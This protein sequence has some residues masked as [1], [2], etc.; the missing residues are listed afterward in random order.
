[1]KISL[2][3]F[4]G[5]ALSACLAA[6]C[7]GAGSDSWT[8]MVYMNSGQ[9]MD[10]FALRDFEQI[11]TVRSLPNAPA[12]FVELGRPF[13]TCGEKW[14]GVR[15]YRVDP[16]SR[17]SVTGG[18]PVHAPRRA[19][20]NSA[21]GEDPVD[22]GSGQTV[23]DFVKWAMSR[24]PPTQHYALIIW[25]HGHGLTLQYS[26]DLFKS[27]GLS[28]P[29]HLHELLEQV[30]SASTGPLGTDLNAGVGAFG[31][32]AANKPGADTV[33]D[34]P[35]YLRDLAD[36]LS[37]VLGPRHLDILAMDSCLMGA[38]ENAWELRNVADYSLAS[39]TNIMRG[40]WNYANLLNALTTPQAPKAAVS[41]I[42]RKALYYG[43]GFDL[44]S[45]ISGVD[46]SQADRMAGLI[47]NLAG[48][49]EKVLGNSGVAAGLYQLRKKSIPSYSTLST[50]AS[51]VDLKLLTQKL[52]DMN[53]SF[54]VNA[55]A[56]ALNRGL[57]FDPNLPQRHDFIV[58]NSSPT[59]DNNGVSIFFPRS[60][61]EWTNFNMSHPGAQSYDPDTCTDS[62]LS[63]KISF[64]CDSKQ[65]W[66]RFIKQLI[67]T[68]PFQ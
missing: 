26:E 63:F 3:F 50:E 9:G 19:L 68:A 38:F 66:P 14:V 52:R 33:P 7:F 8:V 20:G 10:C 54:D 16:L 29:S 4:A 60:K 53:L 18:K 46:L 41:G 23:A 30:D 27:L 45:S 24:N 1:M 40:A 64:V 42:I 6:P 62:T 13:A 12:I 58:D 22:L 15:R 37:R 25:G 55:A 31:G 49:L 28:M 32:I 59:I 47:S 43:G 35:L 51:T 11:T 65:E 48:A 21:G 17:P 57:Q 34:G 2:E 5:L 61:S 36:S 56:D 44:V 39:E 67:S